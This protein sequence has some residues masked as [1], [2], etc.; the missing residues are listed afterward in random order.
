MNLSS[1]F[2]SL[3]VI[4]RGGDSIGSS[5]R[6]LVNHGYCAN[7]DVYGAVRIILD[8]AHTIPWATYTLDSSGKPQPVKA[9]RA[10]RFLDRP[11]AQGFDSLIEEM[12]LSY[13]I[14]GEAFAFGSWPLEIHPLYAGEVTVD[15]VRVIGAPFSFKVSGFSSMVGETYGEDAVCW[16]RNNHPYNR[17]RAVSPLMA[18]L[19][20]L[21]AVNR[22]RV[23]NDGLLK[24]GGMPSMVLEFDKEAQPT[25]E[26]YEETR[27]KIQDKSGGEKNAGKAFI[28]PPQMRVARAGF[29]PA[30]LQ[31]DAMLARSTLEFCRVYNVPPEVLQDHG[32]ATHGNMGAAYKALGVHAVMPFLMKLA[33]GFNSWPGLREQMEPGVYLLPN[34]EGHPLFIEDEGPKQDRVIRAVAGGILKPDEARPVFS[35]AE[36]HPNGIGAQ[37]IVNSAFVRLEDVTN[38]KTLERATGGTGRKD[39]QATNAPMDGGEAA[40][41]R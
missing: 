11:N 16:I 9:P 5:Y 35:Q 18:A 8:T 26:Q 15:E 41:T 6:E 19:K 22:A 12:G 33:D 1:R 30:D 25:P 4:L 2:G 40:G 28:V 37:P 10:Q 3:A 31:W 21:E 34:I 32:N 23:W 14:G 38:G 7:P 17:H 36:A 24:N 27:R 13:L 20:T 29:T 39:G